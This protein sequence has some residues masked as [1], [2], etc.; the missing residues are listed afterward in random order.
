[1]LRDARTKLEARRQ[2]FNEVRPH[3]S[4]GYLT[5]AEYARGSAAIP[6][7]AL[8]YVRAPRAALL[9]PINKTEQVTLICQ[10]SVDLN[11]LAPFTFHGSRR[12][13]L[14]G[15]LAAQCALPVAAPGQIAA[16]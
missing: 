16:T 15:P 14:E 7:G 12:A 8:R 5:P 9:R 2:D 13:G 4:L 10:C 1:L 11:V 6:P 3:S